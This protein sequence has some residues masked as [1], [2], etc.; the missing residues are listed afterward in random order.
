MKSRRSLNIEPP[1]ARVLGAFYA[2]LLLFMGCTVGGMLLAGLGVPFE[3]RLVLNV[4]VAFILKVWVDRI[5][6]RLD[7]NI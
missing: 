7:F 6:K 5:M 2:Y 3:A 4:A 1:S